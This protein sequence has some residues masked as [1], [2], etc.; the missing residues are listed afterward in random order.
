MNEVYAHT[1]PVFIKM[2]SGLSSVLTRAE[3]FAKEKGLDEAKL[4]DQRLIAD[5]SPLKRQVQIATD[6]TNGA[7]AR[8]AG[9]DVPVF[10]D[11]EKSIADLQT[12]I[13]KTIE[14]LKSFREDRFNDADMRQIRPQ[15][16]PE[17]R[18]LAGPD[19]VREYALPNFFF[20]VAMAYGILRQNGVPLGE[21]DY[22]YS[23]PFVD[24]A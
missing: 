18:Y 14:F 9:M 5:M 2:L 8:L 17:D 19:Y 23:L 16:F 7:A 15:Y 6:N 12:R 21:S 1:I 20:H 11:H 13:A 3:L 24:A 22:M 4:L 10:S